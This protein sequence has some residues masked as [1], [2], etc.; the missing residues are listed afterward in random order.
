[1]DDSFANWLAGFI[2]G[3]GCFV[4]AFDKKKKHYH[5]WFS[6]SV[7]KDDAAILHEIVAKTGIGK[8]CRGQNECEKWSVMSKRDTQA[9]ASLLDEYPLRAKKKN[10]YKIWC[11]A[12]NLKKIHIRNGGWG[13]MA[14][15]KQR[16]HDVRNYDL[17]IEKS[18]KV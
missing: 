12:V 11:E 2:D 1:M 15:L 18:Q 10:D 16:L 13:N 3:E 8:V 14:E 7:R 17:F 5:V 4:I 6:L 9:L